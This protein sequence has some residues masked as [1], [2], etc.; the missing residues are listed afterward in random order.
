MNALQRRERLASKGPAA[1]TP[2]SPLDLACP[3]AQ[4]AIE[5]ADYALALGKCEP[6]SYLV[7]SRRSVKRASDTRWLNCGAMRYASEVATTIVHTS[8][9]D[10]ITCQEVEQLHVHRGANQLVENRRDYIE[11][12]KLLY[13]RIDVDWDDMSANNRP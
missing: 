12:A 13:T 4:T 10:L 5:P 6:Y 2:L 3:V 8:G 1:P 9:G 7:P 11:I